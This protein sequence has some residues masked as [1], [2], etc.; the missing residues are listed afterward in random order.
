MS[1]CEIS[2]VMRT[3]AEIADTFVQCLLRVSSLFIRDAMHLLG[4]AFALTSLLQIAIQ[5]ST[6]YLDLH[7]RL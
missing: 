1:G 3:T 5:V 7:E 2:H 6:K 4:A